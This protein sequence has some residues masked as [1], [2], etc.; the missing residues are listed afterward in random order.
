MCPPFIASRQVHETIPR[1]NMRRKTHKVD[2]SYESDHPR[3]FAFL[4][5]AESLHPNQRSL[6]PF[7]IHVFSVSQSHFV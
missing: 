1:K 5:D 3:R 7:L 4:T 6:R 2:L